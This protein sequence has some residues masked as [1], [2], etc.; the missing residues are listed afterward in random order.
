MLCLFSSLM[1]SLCPSHHAPKPQSPGSLSFRPGFGPLFYRKV[2][3]LQGHFS[4]ASCP[5][6]PTQPQGRQVSAMVSTWKQTHSYYLPRDYE[7]PKDTSESN[8][9]L[10]QTDNADWMPEKTVE[11]SSQDN[12]SREGSNLW[13]PFSVQTHRQQW[14]KGK[15]KNIGKVKVI[16]RHQKWGKPLR[17]LRPNKGTK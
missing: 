5:A 1:S 8:S 9:I 13:A 4:G 10:M 2:Y 14:G 12:W 15:K 16:S 17:N 7:H 6:A 3:S 11:I